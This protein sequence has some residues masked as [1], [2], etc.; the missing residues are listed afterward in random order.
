MTCEKGHAMFVR[1]KFTFDHEPNDTPRNTELLTAF[2]QAG[3]QLGAEVTLWYCA[4]CDYAQAEFD[5]G[6]EVLGS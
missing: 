4:E 3:I 1:D 6:E 2:A 5:Y